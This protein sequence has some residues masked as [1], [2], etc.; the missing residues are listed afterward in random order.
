ME[1][2]PKIKQIVVDD[3]QHE[4]FWV[5]FYMA[6]HNG[7]EEYFN[8]VTDIAR[9]YIALPLFVIA[10]VV[11]I[12]LMCVLMSDMVKGRGKEI[13][14]MKSLGIKNTEI[15]KIFGAF[16]LFI[17][18]LQFVIGC[19]LGAGLLY[20][21]NVWWM[22]LADYYIYAPAFFVSGLSIFVMFASVLSIS[23][24][25]LLYSLNK[26]GGQNLRKLFQKQRK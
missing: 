2:S 17:L 10:I 18:F 23:A 16:T 4:N 25:A 12:I 26:F 24:G 15:W 1:L 21:L 20:G 7:N 19:L 11:Y 14:I 13:L 5:D 22:I 3:W 8:D 9:F 6:K